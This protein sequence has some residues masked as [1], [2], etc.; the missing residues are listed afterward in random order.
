MPKEIEEMLQESNLTEKEIII[1][2]LYYIDD[3]SLSEI[4]KMYDSHHY[5][6]SRQIKKALKKLDKCV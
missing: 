1:L 3:K 2:K 5:T 4:A 6:I